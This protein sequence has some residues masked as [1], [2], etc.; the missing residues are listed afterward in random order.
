[1]EKVLMIIVY[2]FIVLAFL[3][4]AKKIADG[5]TKFDDDE[6]IEKDGNI[7]VALRRF[8][9]YVGM[10]ISLSGVMTGGVYRTDFLYF[11]Y[12]GVIATVI[13]FLA[14]Y[15]NDYLIV[16]GVRNN[17][18]VK[19]GNAPTGFAEAGSFIATG[20]I[21]NG[22]FTGEVGGILSCAVFF[23]LGQAMLIAA[24]FVHRKVFRL[25]VVA[26]IKEGNLSAGIAIA[27]L[28]ISYSLILRVSIAGDFAGWLVSLETFAVTAAI[29]MAG[30]LFFQKFA[31]ILFL[32][33]SHFSENLERNNIAAVIVV[34]AIT[35]ALSLVISRLL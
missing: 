20:V 28:L 9:L 1:M 21:L 19:E 26:L 22:A 7:A 16:P 29:G 17:E 15:I 34:Q 14:H 35:I 24:L 25:N 33:K 30:L 6:A 13:F 11:A 18:L 12:H 4:L 32:P 2:V 3:Y 5:L 10:C 27:G 23:F 8:G 31:D